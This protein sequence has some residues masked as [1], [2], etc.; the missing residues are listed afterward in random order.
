MPCRRAVRP[1]LL[2]FLCAVM[3][4][5]LIIV[6]RNT[7]VA[8]EDYIHGNSTPFD[9]VQRV[10]I[11]SETGGTDDSITLSVED[12]E[13]STWFRCLLSH[14]LPFRGRGESFDDSSSYN[15]PAVVYDSMNVNSSLLS[16]LPA[17]LG[18]GFRICKF[19]L[20]PILWNM[21]CGF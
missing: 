1:A 10:T 8:R 18:M 9:I 15:S 4:V 17:G 21:V 20:E 11:G 2:L 14:N 6:P 12:G 3:L 5:P 7:Y 13:S 19:I 16:V